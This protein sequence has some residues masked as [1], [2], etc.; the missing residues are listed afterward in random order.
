MRF[1]DIIEKKKENHP[2]S[3]GE[4]H[5]FITSYVQDKI[6]DY[7]VSA[8][9]MAI[10]FN[11][12]NEQ[13]TAWLTEEMLYSGEVMNLSDI[14]GIKCDKHSTG[15]VGDKTSLALAPMVA[16]CG[17]KI[18]KMS[19]R[20]LGHTGGTLD[21]VESIKGFQINMDMESFKHQINS[22]GL[23]IVGQSGNL[24]PADKK[25]YALRDVTATVNSI[26]LIASSIMSKKLACGADTI[27]LDVKFGEGAFMQTK[28]DAEKLAKTMIS[29]GKH[30]H[31]DVRAMI[32]NMNEPL[33]NAIG[34]A[35]EVKEAIAT[36]K[37]E[38]PKDFY[39][40]CLKAGS[41]MLM[42]AKKAENES[43]ARTMLETAVHNGSALQK[44]ID[45]V[46]AQHGDIQMIKHPETLPQA[47][48]ILEI[49]S[50]EEGYVE[51]VHAL[52]L[53]TLA[54][55]LGAGRQ[56]KEDIIDPSV[57]IVLQKKDGD[58]VKKGDILA[59]VHI[60]HALPPHWLDDFYASYHFTKTPVEKHDLIYKVI[61]E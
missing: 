23:A 49:K 44:L 22:I 29:I 60:N 26:P 41:I 28:E 13:E 32:S 33:G 17:V 37:G 27:L 55:Q 51:E 34:N 30:F 1:V 5:E 10:C 8:L 24:V 54:M 25:L 20:G 48:E 16:A 35:L 12:M 47:K 53:G 43:E 58:Y 7:Q 50:R 59:Y 45:M 3:K 36:L 2:L 14:A 52:S 38:G 40:L 18:A 19:G 57:G 21:K 46:E 56:V 4:I 9:L 61:E 11:G 6:P 31:K 15:G 42:Q 39:E